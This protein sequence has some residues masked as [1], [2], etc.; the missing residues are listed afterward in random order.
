MAWVALI[1]CGLVLWGGC[2]R[3][4]ATGRAIWPGEMPEAVRAAVAPA[5]AAAVTVAHKIV[6]PGFNVF[7]RAA[8]FA[9]IVAILDAVALAPLV[10]GHYGI[11]RSRLGLLAPLAAIFAA[12]LLTG[13]YGPM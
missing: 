3:I 9:L 13:L 6:A 2:A 12:S 7:L 4:F 10:D 8:L 5:I 11:F 1:A